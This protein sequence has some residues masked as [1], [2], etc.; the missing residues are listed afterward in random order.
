MQRR[1]PVSH[2]G[3]ACWGPCWAPRSPAED[4]RSCRGFVTGHS[5]RHRPYSHKPEESRVSAHNDPSLHSGIEKPA[6]G[7]SVQSAKCTSSEDWPLS[8]WHVTGGDVISRGKV[9][10]SHW[11]G[12]TSL[13]ETPHSRDS[14]W[15][16]H[17]IFQRLQECTGTQGLSAH[18]DAKWNPPSGT[19]LNDPS[20]L[21][22]S[23][24]P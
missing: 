14:P 21:T 18:S 16:A 5:D 24:S 3:S 8:V 23:L 17:Y 15:K 10:G 22:L 19:L 11:D 20:L 9:V 13:V 4:S 2:C 1:A 7:S 6:G 12:Q